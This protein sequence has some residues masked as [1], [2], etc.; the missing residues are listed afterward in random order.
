MHP[1]TR[2]LLTGK[3]SQVGYELERSLQGRGEI[4]APTR[5]AKN[6]VHPVGAHP[7]ANAVARLQ[8]LIAP[9]HVLSQLKW[10]VLSLSKGAPN[11]VCISTP[12]INTKLKYTP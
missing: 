8:P 11:A 4:T 10:P 1:M 7:G 3:T 12:H 9:K 6:S 5:T 2:I